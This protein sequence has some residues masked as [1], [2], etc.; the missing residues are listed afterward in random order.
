MIIKIISTLS[1]I[2]LFGNVPLINASIHP[3][4]DLTTFDFA[5]SVSF[6]DKRSNGSKELLIEK[7]VSLAESKAPARRR[8]TEN[9]EESQGSF[10]VVP[11]LVLGV[12]ALTLFFKRK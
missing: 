1:I 8:G 11:G 10:F 7:V 3:S 5:S 4:I 2:L 9:W 6:I 12:I